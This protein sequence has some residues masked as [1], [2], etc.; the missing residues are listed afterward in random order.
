[1]RTPQ[2]STICRIHLYLRS[3]NVK[4]PTSYDLTWTRRKHWLFLGN[5]WTETSYVTVRILQMFVSIYKRYAIDIADPSSM[6]DA[7]H[8]IFVIEPLWLSGKASERWIQRSEVRFLMGTQIFF[9]LSYARDKMEAQNLPSLL[10][11]STWMN[12]WK[13]FFPVA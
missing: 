2:S 12:V 9:S 1:M 5:V 11:L 8:M 10:F 7:C 3:P 6:Q 13:I 4:M